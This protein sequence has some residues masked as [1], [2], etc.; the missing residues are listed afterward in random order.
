MARFDTPHEVN[1]FLNTFAKRGY[2]QVD[3]A[4]M[5]SPQAPGTSEPRIG[6]VSARQSFAIDTKVGGR[7]AGSHSKNNVLKEIDTSLEDLKINQINIEY[8]HVPDRATPFLEACEAMDQAH[9]EGKIKLWGL[10]N[11]TAEETQ[12]FI[13]ICEE[14]DLVKPSVYQGPYNPII[15]SSEKELF[16]VLRKNGMA[17]YA[18]SPGAGGFFAGNHKNAK[19]GGRYDQSVGIPFPV[20]ASADC[21]TDHVCFE[22]LPRAKCTRK[23]T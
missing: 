23:Y 17:F 8:L 1:G 4:R 15:R 19:A 11:Y 20:G 13:D 6:A 9:K 3:T 21:S 22:S 7:E 5:Y 10:S 18:Y 14:H 12:S 2:H 16:A